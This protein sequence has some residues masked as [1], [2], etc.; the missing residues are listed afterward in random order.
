[1]AKVLG[2]PAAAVTR[3]KSGTLCVFDCLIA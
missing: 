3:V 2:A 1:M